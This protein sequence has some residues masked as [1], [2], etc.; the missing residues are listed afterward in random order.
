[1]I[2]RRLDE[3]GDYIFGKYAYE[4]EFYKNKPETVAQAVST[5]LQLF[6]GSWF[7]DITAGTPYNSAIL[8]ENTLD[9]YSMA[10]KEVILDT[11][12]LK[13][14]ITYGSYVNMINRQASVYCSFDTVYGQ[15]TLQQ[16]V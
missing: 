11:P 4:D 5:R 13:N 10:I 1:M 15:T 3:N 14:I 2:Y 8:G 16:A 9:T 7:L 6:Q 12:G